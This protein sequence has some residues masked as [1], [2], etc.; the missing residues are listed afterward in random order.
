MEHHIN[1]MEKRGPGTGA[2]LAVSVLLVMLSACSWWGESDSDAVRR[3][4]IA[5]ELDE[6]GVQVDELII[7]LSPGD[8]RADFGH[9]SRIVW[10]VS[11]G[12]QRVYREGEYFRVRDPE[13]SYL[14]VQDITYDHSYTQA[15]VRVVLYPASGDR[16]TKEIALHKRGGSWEVS[17]ER[18]LQSGEGGE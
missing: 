11:P 17:S 1:Q 14:F 13:R 18:V 15:S 6:R 12:Y 16:A 3:A 7:R 5:H 4:V 10:L 9:G 8:F 2:V